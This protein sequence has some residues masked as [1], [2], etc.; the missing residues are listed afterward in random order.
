VCVRRASLRRCVRPEIVAAQRFVPVATVLFVTR[1]GVLRAS[2]RA[3]L[4]GNGAATVASAAA[5][6]HLQT[7]RSV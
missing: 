3:T 2:A 4:R 5:P 7:W 6:R 1:R